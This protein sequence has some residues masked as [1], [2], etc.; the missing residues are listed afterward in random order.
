MGI[1]ALCEFM[2]DEW[3]VMDWYEQRTYKVRIDGEVT[4][5]TISVQA[6]HWYQYCMEERTS[7]RLKEAGVLTEETI[8]GCNLGVVAD[9]GTMMDE[10][11]RLAKV[12]KLSYMV[13]KKYW[14]KK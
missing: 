3:P 8:G 2:G 9:C 1:H 10:M 7:G 5:K 12:G 4:E 13:P 6:D 11:I 14:K